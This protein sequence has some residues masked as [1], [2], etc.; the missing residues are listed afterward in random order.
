MNRHNVRVVGTGVR[1]PELLI[2]TLC[3][4]GGALQKKLVGYWARGFGRKDVGIHSLQGGRSRWLHLRKGEGWQSCW[5]D[6]PIT[7]RN[8]TISIY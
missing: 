1:K 8:V 2:G 7:H 5:K 4:V 3:V 6:Y